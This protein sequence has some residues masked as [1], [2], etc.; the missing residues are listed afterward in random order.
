MKTD[1]PCRRAAVADAGYDVLPTERRGRAR[2]TSLFVFWLS[3]DWFSTRSSPYL[4]FV[5]CCIPGD[6]IV[7]RLR[8]L[9][10]EFV[11]ALTLFGDAVWTAQL[12]SCR[13]TRKQSSSYSF[14]TAGRV[15]YYAYYHIPNLQYSL[16]KTLL[17]MD[18]WG[19]K[20]VELT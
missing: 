7:S 10:C 5:P 13:V 3:W 17:M 20:H 11:F 12:I 6:S 14:V 2:R 9:L 18:R 8:R 1:L 16:Y 4:D 15:D 19:P